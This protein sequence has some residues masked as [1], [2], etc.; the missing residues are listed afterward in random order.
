MPSCIKITFSSLVVKV[1]L[2]LKPSV[3]YTSIFNK[4]AICIIKRSKWQKQKINNLT[5][6]A[7]NFYIIYFNPDFLVFLGSLDVRLAIMFSLCSASVWLEGLVITMKRKD[8]GGK[9]IIPK[10]LELNLLVLLNF[11][12]FFFIIQNYS[13]INN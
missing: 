4:R 2:Y 12:Y 1:W 8:P 7:E 9:K 13:Y 3:F 6:A 10:S 5:N 11:F